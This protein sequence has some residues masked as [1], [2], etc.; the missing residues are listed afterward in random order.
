MSVGL[1]VR[2]SR[3]LTGPFVTP[4]VLS[5]SSTREGQVQPLN[6]PFRMRSL[7]GEELTSRLERG[8]LG[9]EPD[10]RVVLEHSLREV[11][12]IDSKQLIGAGERHRPLQCVKR[13]VSDA[14]V[15]GQCR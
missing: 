4:P 6:R 7:R 3:P 8:L 13:G 11:P 10:L 14:T 12:A 15:S 1:V 9:I 2:R 5:L